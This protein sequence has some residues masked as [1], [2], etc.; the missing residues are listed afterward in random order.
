MERLIYQNSQV[1]IVPEWP[2]NLSDYIGMGWVKR[3]Y[4]SEGMDEPSQDLS[5]VREAYRVKYLVY[6]LYL[7]HTT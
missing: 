7:F 1:N 6:R 4:S 5:A 2:Y 3:A